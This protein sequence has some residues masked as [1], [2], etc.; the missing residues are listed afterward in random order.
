MGGVVRGMSLGDQRQLLDRA[1]ETHK[2]VIEQIFE[3]IHSARHEHETCER[4]G[5]NRAMKYALKAKLPLLVASADRFSRTL[6]TYVRFREA[7]GILIVL[8]L[9]LDA[10]EHCIW[11]AIQ[12]AE[13][14]VEKRQR[15][16]KDGQARARIE[17]RH[18]G[19]PNIGAAQQT[20]LRVRKSNKVARCALHEK[21]IAQAR[22]EGAQTTVEIVRALNRKRYKTSQGRAW[23]VNN[24]E[25][26]INLIAASAGRDVL[27]SVELCQ[28]TPTDT[29]DS[30]F[31]NSRG[32][33]TAVGDALGC[34]DLLGNVNTR[35]WAKGPPRSCKE[36]SASLVPVA[37]N[38]NKATE[39]PDPLSADELE[40]L[41][42]LLKT[43]CRSDD[44]FRSL[45]AAASSPSLSRRGRLSFLNWITKKLNAEV[46]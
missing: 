3:D 28:S 45:Y 46:A 25:R 13:S 31:E 42:P 21:W 32:G 10:P 14:D 1:G 22:A 12:H 27:N 38:K 39:A 9:G 29:N 20:S 41:R 40:M 36:R 30:A 16:A 35:L 24:L 33:A 23:K 15:I 6:A 7:G 43:Y 44:Q 19:N 2:F 5:L 18:P 34:L 4:T 8:D 11:A 26:V 37:A 17:G